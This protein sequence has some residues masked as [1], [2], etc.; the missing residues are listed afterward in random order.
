[1][2][3]DDPPKP[4]KQKKI[5]SFFIS[6]VSR[7]D[8]A[9]GESGSTSNGGSQ[10][11]KL[12]LNVAIVLRLV[13]KRN[14]TNINNEMLLLNNIAISE[15]PV[16]VAI[17]V[18]LVAT[19]S[20]VDSTIVP[21]SVAL[22]TSGH[23]NTSTIAVPDCSVINVDLNLEAE[24]KPSLRIKIFFIYVSCLFSFPSSYFNIGELGPF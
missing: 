6:K 19:T 22:T 10:K 15:C 17:S 21:A 12:K 20:T 23:T 11:R 24:G 2:D 1:M 5:E 18:P 8:N 3:S 9:A 4:K 16:S 14:E 7:D 13:A